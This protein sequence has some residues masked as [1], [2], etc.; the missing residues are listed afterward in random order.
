MHK[1]CC[2]WLCWLCSENVRAGLVAMAGWL[3]M[4]L[5]VSVYCFK[6]VLPSC[7][8]TLSLWHSFVTTSNA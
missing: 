8:G 5:F 1:G 2:K 3:H 4:G 7:G 6:F